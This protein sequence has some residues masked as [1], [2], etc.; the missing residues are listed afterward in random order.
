MSLKS[1]PTQRAPDPGKIR[2]G[3]DGGTA[4]SLRA[5]FQAVFWAQARSI[6]LAL[7]RPTTNK[8]NGL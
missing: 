8:L 7:S 5:R 4:A 2:R 3:H 6:K 1:R